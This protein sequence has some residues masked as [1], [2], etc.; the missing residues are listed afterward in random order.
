MKLTKRQKYIAAAAD[1]T[2][3]GFATKTEVRQSKFIAR[4][5]YWNEKEFEQFCSYSPTGIRAYFG[6]SWFSWATPKQKLR[7]IKEARSASRLWAKGK[8]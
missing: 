4:G 8:Y 1:P 3:G 7:D 2:Y 5:H 6:Y